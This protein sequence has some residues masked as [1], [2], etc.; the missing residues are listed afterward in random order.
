MSPQDLNRYLSGKA[1]PGNKIQTRLRKLGCDIE[2]LMTGERDE[3]DTAIGLSLIPFLGKITATPDGKEYFDDAINEGAG[4]PFFK[5]NYFALEVENDSMINAI[6]VE[7][8]P[9]DICIFELGRQPKNGDIVAVQFKQTN[10]RTVKILKH[11]SRDEVE[12]ISANKYRNY[13]SR[14]VRKNIIATFG[15]FVTKFLYSDEIRTKLKLKK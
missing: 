1:V 3:K 2:W 13:P 7:I 9:G 14:R 4:V 5:G 12:L 8:Y 11:V 15:I 10:E 6:P